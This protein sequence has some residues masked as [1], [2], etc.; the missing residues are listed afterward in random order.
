MGFEALL[1][2]CDVVFTGEGRLDSQSIG[3]KTISGIG[4][5]A[6]RHDVPVVILA[7]GILPET[8]GICDELESGISAVFS[9][10]RQAM[11]F[12]QSRHD[13]REN[14]ARTFENILRLIALA[15]KM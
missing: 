1:E 11:A 7:G 2:S 10:N 9:I 14:Y 3:G 4:K 8:E 6:R 12:E 5:R 15:G 13:S